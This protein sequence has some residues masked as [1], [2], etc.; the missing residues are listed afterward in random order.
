METEL[1]LKIVGVI[2]SK[3]IEDVVLHP[4]SLKL[5][6]KEIPSYDYNQN[7]LKNLKLEEDIKHSLFTQISSR[8]ETRGW[9]A[10]V[11]NK[12]KL[13]LFSNQEL[14]LRKQLDPEFT[15]KFTQED[16][17]W[18]LQTMGGITLKNIVEGCYRLK[19]LKYNF[20]HEVMTKLKLVEETEDGYIIEVFFKHE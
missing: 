6:W 20:L 7:L 12:S 10:Q 2:V 17:V 8:I 14:E 15:N 1:K 18:T 16:F 19:A 5:L 3:N 11:L 9:N 4:C 13:T